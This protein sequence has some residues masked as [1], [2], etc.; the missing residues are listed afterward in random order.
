MSCTIS[1]ITC[2]VEINCPAS[3]VKVLAKTNIF[4][5][6]RETVFKMLSMR[7]LVIFNVPDERFISISSQVRILHGSHEGF[8][9]LGIEPDFAEVS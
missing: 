3:L 9:M 6:I 8:L 2:F 4:R 1:P 5:K 7:D